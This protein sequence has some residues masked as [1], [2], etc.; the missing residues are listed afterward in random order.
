MPKK[1]KEKIAV[2][3]P[4]KK[5]GQSLPKISEIEVKKTLED[6][7]ADFKLKFSSQKIVGQ[8]H[9]KVTCLPQN[10]KA[11]NLLKKLGIGRR[12][13]PKLVFYFFAGQSLM[14]RFF[15]RT[16]ALKSEYFKLFDQAVAGL[17]LKKVD[18]FPKGS[19]LFFR[20][21]LHLIK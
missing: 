6:Y 19:L 10:D 14:I 17:K 21:K 13:F 18:F 16:K 3:Y 15:P 20:K 5:R 11:K 9:V 1:D 4:Q 7:F 8:P 2:Y 12:V